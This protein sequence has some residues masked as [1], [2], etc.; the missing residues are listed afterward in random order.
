MAEAREPHEVRFFVRETG[1]KAAAMAHMY[2]T[3]WRYWDV[4][5]EALWIEAAGYPVP[6]LEPVDG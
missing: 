2:A 3:G 5:P 1:A 6:E 4:A